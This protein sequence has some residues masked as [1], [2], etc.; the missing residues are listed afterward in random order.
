[1]LLEV[2]ERFQLVQML[3]AEGKY[4][5]LKTIR[6]QRESLSFEPEEIKTLSLTSNTNPD[7]TVSNT[8]DGSKAP[9]VVKDVP[10]DEYMT[11]F[12]RKELA[13]IEGEGKLNENLVSLYEKFVVIGFK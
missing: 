4:E 1:M 6:R 7:G 2:H 13:K 10:I 5:A 9:L 3:P 11:N 12:F 8:W